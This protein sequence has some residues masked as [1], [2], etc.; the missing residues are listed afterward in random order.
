MLC[1][2][3]GT[4]WEGGWESLE[5]VAHPSS[6]FSPPSKIHHGRLNGEEEEE[7]KPL[8]VRLGCWV[9]TMGS[10]KAGSGGWV[11]DHVVLGSSGFSRSRPVSSLQAES[12]KTKLDY[13]RRHAN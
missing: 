3:P 12:G 4:L 7:S 6:C 9:T 13:R 10:Y 8:T 2:L 1:H 11:S 5:C